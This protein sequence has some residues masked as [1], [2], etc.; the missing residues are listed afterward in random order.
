MRHPKNIAPKLISNQMGDIFP[1]ATFFASSDKL[2]TVVG[3]KSRTN[4]NCNCNCDCNGNP[5]NNAPDDPNT[6]A[7]GDTKYHT[8]CY[9]QSDTAASP[10]S[11]SSP[12]PVK[13]IAAS[14]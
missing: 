4:C 9:A 5:N 1:S 13:A 8:K 10:D 2:G 14:I 3:G 12:D 7:D 6:N 11:A